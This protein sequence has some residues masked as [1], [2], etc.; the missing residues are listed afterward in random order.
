MGP[1][2][3]AQSVN[4]QPLTW[5]EGVYC[6]PLRRSLLKQRGR[7]GGGGQAHSGSSEE[8]REA[9]LPATASQ[10]RNLAEPSVHTSALA[11]SPALLAKAMC[12]RVG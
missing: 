5:C 9:P 4:A 10:G 12:F 2:P 3:A 6:P 1:R 11:L 7:R 8:A